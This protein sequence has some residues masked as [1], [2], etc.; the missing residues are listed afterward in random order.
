ML[1][2]LILILSDPL[3]VVASR[4]PIR[5]ERPNGR[6]EAVVGVLLLVQSAALIHVT[7]DARDQAG[8]LRLKLAGV[9]AL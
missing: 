5:Q 1:H 2:Q 4:A 7:L 8:L 9:K 3:Q 6:Q